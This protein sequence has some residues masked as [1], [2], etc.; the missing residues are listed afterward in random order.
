MNLGIE[1]RCALLLLA[2]LATCS[3]CTR[4]EATAL[5]LG[6]GHSLNPAPSGDELK[7]LLALA[8]PTD[9]ELFGVSQPK[10]AVFRATAVPA[11][12]LA[13]FR[14][15]K[16]LR[17]SAQPSFAMENDHPTWRWEVNGG[18]YV[19]CAEM[20]T[21]LADRLKELGFR[22][23]QENIKLRPIEFSRPL[24]VNNKEVATE[25]VTLQ[26]AVPWSGGEII[27]GTSANGI[28]LTWSIR[29]QTATKPPTVASVLAAAPILT[30]SSLD[31]THLP[32][33]ILLALEKQAAIRVA[34]SHG[35][36]ESYS[37]LVPSG[38]SAP[39]A[40]IPE[41]EAILKS[42]GFVPENRQ[43]G[44]GETPWLYYYRKPPL[45]AAPSCEIR[46]TE[47]EGEYWISISTRLK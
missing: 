23:T 34:T 31:K 35:Y 38:A 33:E 44:R 4:D 7:Q 37:V 25:I 29:S 2:C 43:P 6:S 22:T 16:V 17:L 26:A 8:K 13:L 40:I 24:Q 39:P 21:R 30:P 15:E 10:H 12:L 41:I 32:K 11:D 28:E 27:D 20:D 47:R 46:V 42:S 9:G 14:P 36:Y 19:P 5:P 1:Y 3:S 18:L 45:P